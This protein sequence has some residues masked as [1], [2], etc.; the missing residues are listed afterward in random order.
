MDYILEDFWLS[1]CM[2]QTIFF[3]FDLYPL[4]VICHNNAVI[5]QWETCTFTIN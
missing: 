2:Q 3:A 5:L 4:R 1:C